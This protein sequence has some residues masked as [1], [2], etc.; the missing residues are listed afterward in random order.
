MPSAILYSCLCSVAVAAAALGLVSHS[1]VWYS[2]GDGYD[3]G[4][5][6]P[7]LN[8]GRSQYDNNILS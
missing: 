1:A 2:D 6:G 5:L 3:M 7:V 4:C 8:K